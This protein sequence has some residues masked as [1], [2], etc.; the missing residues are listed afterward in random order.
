[1][2]HCWWVCAASSIGSSVVFWTSY[3]RDTG[4][5]SALMGSTQVPCC[6][7]CNVLANCSTP[8]RAVLLQQ[9]QRYCLFACLF[10]FILTLKMPST[11][12]CRI[13]FEV[14]IV[15]PR[16]WERLNSS[17]SEYTCSIG[18]AWSY[19][20]FCRSC[21]DS[22]LSWLTFLTYIYHLKCHISFMCELLRILTFL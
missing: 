22:L 4:C 5:S 6:T 1:M 21:H 3:W 9:L 11:S 13:C 18:L 12:F 14:E 19:P 8:Q 20:H 16:K 17:S 2:L 10:A 7:T 15:Q